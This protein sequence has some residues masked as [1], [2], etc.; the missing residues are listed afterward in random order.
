MLGE[1]VSAAGAGKKYAPASLGWDEAGGGSTLNVRCRRL[2][3]F[4]FQPGSWVPEVRGL[5]GIAE[6][7]Q[8][9]ALVVLCAYGL[10]VAERFEAHPLAHILFWPSRKWRRLLF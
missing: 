10:A 3:H 8:T 1:V 6:L 9:V 4:A 2:C 7:A 5:A